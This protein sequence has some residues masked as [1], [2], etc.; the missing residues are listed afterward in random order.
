MNP[1][2]IAV[3]A[4]PSYQLDVEFANGE[5]RIFDVRPYLDKGVFRLLKDVR[6]FAAARI[7]AGSVEW[8]GE[9][10]LSYDTL[11]LEGCDREAAIDNLNLA[12]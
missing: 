2:A 11:Y 1:K 9:I 4:L 5:R 8:P 12:H 6:R 10:D 7:V 3:Y